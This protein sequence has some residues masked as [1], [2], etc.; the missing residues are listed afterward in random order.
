M[1]AIAFLNA[2]LRELIIAKYF[3]ELHSHQVSTL[4]LLLFCTFYI[5]LVFPR[6]HVKKAT[7]ALTVGLVW[8]VCTILFEFGLGILTHHSLKSLIQ[9][10]NISEGKIWPVFLVSLLLLPYLLYRSMK[11]KAG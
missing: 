4:T 1:I 9:E 6:L 7:E 11:Q 2:T 3:N 10:Y 5:G 8:T